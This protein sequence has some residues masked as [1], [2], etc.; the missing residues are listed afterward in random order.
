VLGESLAES[1]IEVEYI[2]DAMALAGYIVVREEFGFR[3]I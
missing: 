3:P 2:H 1:T